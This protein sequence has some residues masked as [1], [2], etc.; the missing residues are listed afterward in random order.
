M[1]ADAFSRS[2][3]TFLC[4]PNFT[5]ATP[6][7]RNHLSLICS[8]STPTTPRKLTNRKNYLRQKLLKTLIKPYPPNSLILESPQTN[9]PIPI[10][11]ESEKDQSLTSE[12]FSGDYCPAVVGEEPEELE[13][14]E[15]REAEI[16]ESVEIL[17]GGIGKVSKNS[18]FKYGLWLVG[19]FVVQ[20]ICAVWVFKSAKFEDKSGNYLNNEDKNGVLEVRLNGKSNSKVK[21]IRNA[22]MGLENGGVV[23]VDED[24]MEKK[25]EEIRVMAREARERERLEMKKDGF[26]SEEID[27]ELEDEFGK[28]GIEKEVNDRLVKLQKRLEN[29]HGTLPV[30]LG[31][32]VKKDGVNE[33]NSLGGKEGNRAL[34][35]KKKY[36]FRALSSKPTDK[37][38]GF[39]GLYDHG[40]G[41]EVMSSK[42]GG[43][44][45]LMNGDIGGG[46]VDSVDDMRQ[47]D[48]HAGDS[49]A[50]RSAHLEEDEERQQAPEATKSSRNAEKKF[51]KEKDSRKQEKK[52]GLVN[53]KSNGLTQDR[54]QGKPSTE[55]IKSRKSKILEKAAALSNVHDVLTQNGSLKGGGTEEDQSASEIGQNISESGTDSWWLNLPYV[56]VIL[57]RRGVDD[58]GPFTLR[59]NSYGKSNLSHTVAFEDRGDATNFCYL[60]QSSFEDLEDFSAE[61]VP[62]SIK[63]LKE[64]VESLTLKVIVVKKGQL[65]LYA[66]QPLPE[67]E[68]AL[69]SLVGQS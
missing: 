13:I 48:L 66:G 31:D 32:N 50:G 29:A 64:A 5:T 15:F 1:A 8:I 10:E 16:Q 22:K 14:E 6:I 27:K 17:D 68:M 7:P 12:Q 35:F 44:E 2:C 46:V 55:A 49:R 69:R 53:S 58:V 54:N 38:K 65:K 40:D 67:V 60:L 33:K 30:G 59:S 24:E 36:R 42:D 23:F 47:L 20:T 43:A 63:E 51:V 18:I 4:F 11:L 9:P 52:V 26:E 57:M 37:P 61:I 25:I 62:L 21:F 56:L 45:V 19:A 39:T 3:N 41:I 34:M 28:T